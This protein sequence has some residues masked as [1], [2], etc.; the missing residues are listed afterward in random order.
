MEGMIHGITAKTAFTIF[1]VAILIM[2]PSLNNDPR[3]NRI[4]SYTIVAGILAVLLI[5]LLVILDDRISWFGFLERLLV[6][7][8]I[9]WI[10]VAG[11]NLLIISLKKQKEVKSDNTG[12]EIE[13]KLV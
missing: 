9:V 1:P 4:F 11:V 6:A 10:E 5:I 3:W 8:M 7:N 2:A 12:S 13:L